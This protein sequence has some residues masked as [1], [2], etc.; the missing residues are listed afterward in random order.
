MSKLK[1]LKV[2]RRVYSIHYRSYPTHYGWTAFN[3]RR[4]YLDDISEDEQQAYAVLHESLHAIWEQKNLVTRPTE[5]KA[6]TQLG[7]GLVELFR[8]NPGLLLHLEKLVRPAR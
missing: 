3:D 5:E 7:W 8:D 6:V 4:I 1:R 2:G